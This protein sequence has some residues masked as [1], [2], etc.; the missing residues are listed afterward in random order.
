MRLT[1]VQLTQLS[2]ALPVPLPTALLP[3]EP[4]ANETVKSRLLVMDCE[5]VPA[6]ADGCDELLLAYVDW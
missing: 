4:D 3:P 5:I 6:S 1:G 2:S